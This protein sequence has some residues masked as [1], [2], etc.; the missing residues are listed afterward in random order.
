MLGSWR[1]FCNPEKW[2]K[3][4]EKN[5]KTKKSFILKAKT[6]KIVSN[7]PRVENLFLSSKLPPIVVI[8]KSI[9]V[10]SKLAECWASALA[11]LPYYK[12]VT[13]SDAWRSS[14]KIWGLPWTLHRANSNQTT[15]GQWWVCRLRSRYCH[16]LS[17]VDLTR[18]TTTDSCPRWHMP[19][20]R[21]FLR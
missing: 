8:V 1:R 19:L 17:W 12:N 14:G 3:I 4:F 6:I 5:N 11:Q 20:W 16:K 10:T 9:V 7:I 18:V 15:F 2:E 13:A 21:K